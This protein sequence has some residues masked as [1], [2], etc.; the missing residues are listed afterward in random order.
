MITYSNNN[1]LGSIK[2]SVCHADLKESTMVRQVGYLFGVV[3][4][5]CYHRFSECDIELMTN[6]FIAYGGY[7]GKLRRNRADFTPERI[8][9][10]IFEELKR[11]G[12]KLNSTDLNV[13]LMHKALLYGLTPNEYVE[14]LKKLAE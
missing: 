5:E 8:L 7:F 4:D 3:C 14:E 10:E 2:C 11:N 13:R 1:N 6:M 12:R 9:T